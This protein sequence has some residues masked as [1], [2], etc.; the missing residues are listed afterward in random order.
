MPT[1]YISVMR[2]PSWLVEELTGR[3]DRFELSLSRYAGMILSHACAHQADYDEG[4]MPNK[5]NLPEHNGNLNIPASGLVKTAIRNWGKQKKRTLNQQTIY[6]L[7]R[8]LSMDLSLKDLHEE[9]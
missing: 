4:E 9:S 6:I 8:S 2:P 3:A 7:K 5:K 1:N